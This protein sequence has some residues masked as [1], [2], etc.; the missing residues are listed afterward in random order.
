[1]SVKLYN[2]LLSSS[3]IN[4]EIG[5]RNSASDWERL[6][7]PA[8]LG[9]LEKKF[10]YDAGEI[11]DLVNSGRRLISTSGGRSS[12]ALMDRAARAARDDLEAM[13]EDAGKI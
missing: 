7:T 3:P 4:P 13:C 12:R 9:V 6:T 1:L 8:L 10:K 11:Y 5:I 2:V